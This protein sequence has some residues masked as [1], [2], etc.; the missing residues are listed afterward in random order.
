M[1]YDVPL[2]GTLEKAGYKVTWQGEGQPIKIEK[3]GQSYDILPGAYEVRDG[4]AYLDPSTVPSIMQKA[5]YQ[6]VREALPP[7]VGYQYSYDEPT[8]KVTV[9]NIRGGSPYT[10]VSPITVSGRAYVP[11]SEVQTARTVS[12]PP[13]EAGIAQTEKLWSDYMTKQQEAIAKHYAYQDQLLKDYLN[14]V[15]NFTKQYGDA[16]LAMLNVYQQHY[17]QALNQLQKL[18]QPDTTV[19]ETVKVALSLL[20]KDL[21]DNIQR[22][23]EEMNRRGIY[24]SGLA[25]DMERKLREGELTEEQKILAQWLDDVHQRAYDAALRYADYLTKYASGMA[26]LYGTAYLKPIEL[27]S[28]AASE[29]YKLSSGLAESRFKAESD[30]QAQ[31][32]DVLSKLR[33]MAASEAQRTADTMLQRQWE[34]EDWQRQRQAKLEDWEREAALQRELAN[35]LAN[36]SSA[37]SAWAYIISLLGQ[38]GTGGGS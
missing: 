29:A 3:G 32:F 37:D 22:L 8:G 11:Q 12:G 5:G 28:R 30:L 27:A 18:M 2:R 34:L 14:Q 24:Q 36:V 26:D 20:Q 6:W 25:A 38:A 16:A 33:Q 35:I 31:A 19:P 13:Y 9:S 4:T 7:S 10:F 17:Q 1:A 21:Q 15:N 23:N